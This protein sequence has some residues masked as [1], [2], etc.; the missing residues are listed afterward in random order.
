M[1]SAE[2]SRF[3]ALRSDEERLAAIERARVAMVSSPD[4]DMRKVADNSIA[5][6]FLLHKL[7]RDTVSIVHQEEERRR[8]W[9]DFRDR[10]VVKSFQEL[11]DHLRNCQECRTTLETE[12]WFLQLSKMP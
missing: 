8:G 11:W 10:R 4:V 12:I 2:G 9:F 3:P 1:S 5:V 7:L 6:S